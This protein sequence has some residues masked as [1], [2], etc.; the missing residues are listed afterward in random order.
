MAMDEP[1][2]LHD[3]RRIVIL[4]NTGFIGRRLE[5]HFRARLPEMKLAGRSMPEIDLT[6]EGDVRSL[7]KLLDRHTVLLMLAGIKRQVGDTQEAFSQ[8]VKMAE[9]LCCA[10]QDY[11]VARFV[12]FSSAAVY[13]EDIHNT[14]IREETPVHPTSYYGIA[15]Y[16]SECL[17]RKMLSRQ[18]NSWLVLRPATIYGPGEPSGSYG[19][20][21]FLKAALNGEAITLWGDGREQRE[22]I[23][24]DDLIDLTFRLTFHEHCGVLNIASGTSYSFL[25]VLEVISRLGYGRIQVASKPRTKNKVDHMFSNN[26]LMKLFPAFTFTTLDQGI[27]RTFEDEFQQASLHPEKVAG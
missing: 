11:P 26:A 2:A 10:L 7:Q 1:C 3:I 27:R 20:S 25:D 4:G 9:N 8:N 12:Y 21:G 13:G 5:A 15:K 17:F 19:P 23:F 6:V 16:T 18:N 22:F 24:I 14:R